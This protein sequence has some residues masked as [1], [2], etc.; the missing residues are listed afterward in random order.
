MRV[1]GVS[2]FC[3]GEPVDRSKNGFPADLTTGV[4][5][6]LKSNLRGGSN[7]GGACSPFRLLTNPKRGMGRHK[8]SP[9]SINS[10][11]MYVRIAFFGKKRL[12]FWRKMNTC[13]SENSC[14]KARIFAFSPSR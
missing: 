11:G 12:R 7:E 9:S 4:P 1:R 2:I 13:Q 3:A 6:E 5:K 8:A 10:G 14:H